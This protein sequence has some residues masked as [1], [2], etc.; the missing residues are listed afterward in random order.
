MSTKL[1]GVGVRPEV[2]LIPEDGLLN[3]GGVII[4][5]YVEKSFEISNVSNFPIKFSLLSKAK[6]A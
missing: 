2:K 3:V 6:G 4:G 1:K 5:E